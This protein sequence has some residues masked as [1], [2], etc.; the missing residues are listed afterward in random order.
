MLAL[1]KN[2]MEDIIHQGG[3][4][5]PVNNVWGTIFQGRIIFTINTGY[6]R[7]V[8]PHIYSRSLLCLDHNCG[9]TAVGSP[10]PP[11]SPPGATPMPVIS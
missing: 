6:V 7:A 4:Y 10:N 5:S 11:P 9:P 3:Q 8:R 1:T 2:L